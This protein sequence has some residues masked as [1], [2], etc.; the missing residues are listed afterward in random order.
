MEETKRAAFAKATAAKVTTNK[1]QN[2]EQPAFG[3]KAT[4]GDT[5]NKQLSL[6]PAITPVNV[7]HG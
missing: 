3:D 4:A 6:Q 7:V 1:R 5:T 2:N